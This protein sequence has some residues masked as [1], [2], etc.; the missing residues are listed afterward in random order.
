MKI[1]RTALFACL[2]AVAAGCVKPLPKEKPTVETP[3]PP[4]AL[5]EKTYGEILYGGVATLLINY[6]DINIIADPSFDE[7]GTA[8]PPYPQKLEGVSPQAHVIKVEA[9]VKAGAYPPADYLLL[10]DL[11]PHHFGEGQGN[12]L[13]KNMK[14]LAPAGALPAL[15]SLG[16]SNA[17]E[18]EPGQRML[19]EKNKSFL[20]VG[21]VQ[22]PNPVSGD[23]VNG[24]LLEFDNGRNIFIGG[25]IVDMTVLREFLYALRDDGKEIHIAFIY[26]GGIRSVGGALESLDEKLAAEMI[27]LFQPQLAVIVQATSLSV[28]KTDEALLRRLLKEEIFFGQVMVPKPGDRIPF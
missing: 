5:L 3:A 7:P 13:R 17:K 25:E 9:S 24:Y 28:T 18:L 11:E 26:A 14:V 23:P 19:L 8:L 22:A 12:V 6:K 4:P 15:L 2:F 1:R 20:F 27:A 10:T 16:Y 21:A